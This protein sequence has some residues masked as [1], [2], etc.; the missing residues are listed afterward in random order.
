MSMPSMQAIVLAAGRSS[1]FKSGSTK[2]LAPICGQSMILYVLRILSSQNIPTTVVLSPESDDVRAAIEASGLSGITYATQHNPHGTGHAVSCTQE[3]WEKDHVLILNGDAPL[4]TSSLINTLYKK[5][6]S[7]NIAISFLSS[8]VLDPHGYGR[9]MVEGERISIVEEQECTE[10]QRS[11]HTINAGIYL[12]ERS[13]LSRTIDRLPTSPTTGET[14][15]TDLVGYA[16]QSKTHVV[17]YD[18][19]RGV[20]TLDDLWAVEQIKRSDIIKHWLYQGVRFELPLT[21]HVD[22][23]VTIG[24]GTVISGG[25]QLLGTT[26]IG[27]H[28]TIGPGS[29]LRDAQIA[30]HVAIYSHT[31][32]EQSSIGARSHIGPFVRLRDHVVV[33]EAVTIGNFVEIKKSHIGKGTKAKHLAYLGDAQIGSNVNIGAGTITCNHD[34]TKKHLT[35]IEDNAFVGSNNT[36]VAPV[37]IGKGAYTAAGSTITSEVPA[38]DLAIGRSRQVNKTGYADRLRAKKEEILPVEKPDT[39]QSE[40]TV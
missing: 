3:L 7:S 13:Y 16:E 4:I 38:G 27:T 12:V 31:V 26:S 22:I 34:G 11:I 39:S 21:T 25:V 2:Q 28:C 15:I 19:V 18:Y 36:L 6:T 23:G 35:T 8:T 20:N 32:I 29:V 1:R 10:E 33:D 30:D 24:A 9:V 37:K 17:P 40:G 14:Y 5:H